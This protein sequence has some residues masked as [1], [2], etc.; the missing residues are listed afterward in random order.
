MRVLVR[1]NDSIGREARRVALASTPLR[2]R[3][4]RTPRRACRSSA[5]SRYESSEGETAGGGVL[6]VLLRCVPCP[7]TGEA[8]SW[9]SAPSRMSSHRALAFA[10]SA[11]ASAAVHAQRC[12][13]AA[14]SPKCCGG[15]REN[16]GGSDGGACV[17][18]VCIGVEVGVGGG[19]RVGLGDREC[20]AMQAPLKSS[21][22]GVV[23][24]RA[25]C[26]S[27]ELRGW[28]DAALRL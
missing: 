18:D 7:S 19:A 27:G 28:L 15:E 11:S 3:G 26:S 16:G 8:E 25:Q 9:I 20:W 24:C 4:D 21:S 1:L 13:D 12:C 23:A 22:L 10:S 6:P 2:R 14:S 17:G 5:A